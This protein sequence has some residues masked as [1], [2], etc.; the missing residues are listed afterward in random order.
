MENGGSLGG[1]IYLVRVA[2]G[3]QVIPQIT[4]PPCNVIMSM[5]SR[6]RRCPNPL[7]FFCSGNQ[8]LQCNSCIPS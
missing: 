3:A 5:L 8:R 1:K 4:C 2:C 7:F 6:N